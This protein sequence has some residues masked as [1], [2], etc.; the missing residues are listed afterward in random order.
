MDVPGQVSLLLVEDDEMEVITLKR[1]MKALKLANPLLRAGDGIEA[2][3]ILRGKNG[4]EKLKPPYIILLDINMPRMNGLEFLAEVREDSEL[5]ASIIFVLTTSSADE[6]I[7][8]SYDH[9]VAGYIVK[10]DA[11][12]TLYK[13]FSMLD[14][15]WTL[16]QFPSTKTMASRPD[17]RHRLDTP[18]SS[19]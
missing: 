1:A 16:V 5:R 9:N 15:Y 8:K 7:M 14:Y 2:L 13:A 19:W 18:P 12:T 4:R 6:D 10:G 17:K 11:E 3:D